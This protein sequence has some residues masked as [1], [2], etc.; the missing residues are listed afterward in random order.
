MFVVTGAN[1]QT[2]SVVAKVLLEAG[3][4][5]RAIVRK[6][7]QIEG[8]RNLGAQ[9]VMA[10]LDDQDSLIGA[11]NG[12]SGAYLMNPPAYYNTDLFERARVVHAA[13]IGAAQKAGL[14]HV[15][16]LSSV[17]AQHATGTGNILPTHDFEQQ[18]AVSGL[19]CS[20]LR[21]ANFMENWVSSFASLEQT[22]EL[23]SMFHPLDRTLPMVAARDIG[24][25]A[26]SL[27]LE[28]RGGVVELHGPQPYSPDNV[29]NTLS[30]LLGKSVEAVEAA[31]QDWAKIF[32]SY[33]FPEKTVLAFCDMFDGFNNGRVDFEGNHEVRRG[34]VALFDALKT[35]LI[36]KR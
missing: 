5:V 9:T 4:A 34:N 20:L 3:Y 19:N 35:L 36:Q 21:A 26:A 6:P 18:L 11:F 10:D 33:G 29:A 30:K 32:Q 31:R 13:M 7:V 15:V 25:T 24:Q 28:G 14:P 16:A 8:W 17:G 1:G 27:L 23:P 2:G 22:G 12:A